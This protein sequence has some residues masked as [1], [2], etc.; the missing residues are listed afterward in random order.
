MLPE[1]ERALLLRALLLQEQ[2]LGLELELQRALERGPVLG[3][4][5]GLELEPQAP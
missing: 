5:L 2:A 3:L 1:L 4:E